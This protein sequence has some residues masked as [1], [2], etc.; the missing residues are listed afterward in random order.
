M[1]DLDW[2]ATEKIDESFRPITE[3]T[4]IILVGVTGVGKTT[5]VD[6]LR[7]AD[8]SF[9]LLPNRRS[10]T[11]DLIIAHLQQLDGQ[12]VERVSDRAARFALTR[13]YRDR[14]SGGMAHALT[15]LW[16]RN[17]QLLLFDGLRGVNEIEQAVTA[18]PKANFL[19]LDAPHFV[20][21]R[22][23]LGRGDAFDAVATVVQAALDGIN[24]LG[25]LGIEGVDGLFSTEEETQF[26]QLVN[27]GQ[28]AADDLAAKLKIVSAERANYDPAA[29]IQTL[30][31]LAPS[32][33]WLFD[34]NKLS[35][36]EIALQ[37]KQRVSAL[38]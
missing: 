20:R 9:D 13:R 23:L 26:V 15:K 31:Q 3:A 28:L 8:I 22:R 24:E 30:Q 21:L 10:L 25:D 37:V 14:Y 16:V 7:A 12:P 36:E 2:L 35:P 1:F 18:L 11:D 32:R 34:T 38:V 29:T 17:E 33:T 6:A 27:S 5:T 19:V 4:L